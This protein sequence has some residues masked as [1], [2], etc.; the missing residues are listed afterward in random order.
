[1]YAFL[2]SKYNKR[3]MFFEVNRN[4]LLHFDF[5]IIHWKSNKDDAQ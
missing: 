3:G 1:M 5:A 4:V 2:V